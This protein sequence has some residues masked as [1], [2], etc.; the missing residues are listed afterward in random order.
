MTSRHALAAVF[1]LGVVGLLAGTSVTDKSPA[2]G[3]PIRIESPLPEERF[4]SGEPV[5]LQAAAGPGIDV[6]SL[7]W[8]SSQDG[9]LGKG[10][11]VRVPKLSPGRHT[12]TVSSSGGSR[13]VAVRVFRDLGDFYQAPQSP[14]ERDRV[15]KDFVFAWVDGK[16]EDELWQTYENV[17]FN[18]SSPDPGKAVVLAK[19]DV[20]RHQDFSQPLPFTNGKSIYDHVRTF[21]KRIYVT[22]G[23]QSNTGGHGNIS[24]N[25]NFA[26]WDRRV[27]GTAGDPEACKNAQATVKP[28]LYSGPLYLFVHEARHSEPGE[29]GHVQC[30]GKGNMDGSL[31]NGSGHAAAALY[32]MWVYKYGLYDPPA[33][34][35]DAKLQAHS[36]LKTRFCATPS[37]SNPQV[38]AIVDEILK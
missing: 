1:F 22:L 19:L 23:C 7:R 24:L 36:L 13:D 26:V 35:A 31:E 6:G 3:F 33:V 34:K 15:A 18:Q 32:L 16:S 9:N 8:T 27:S 37:H 5:T 30:N 25:R 10:Q 12:I 4:V 17:G 11:A 21:V 2:S 14:A 38:Q 20:L 28:G 29:P